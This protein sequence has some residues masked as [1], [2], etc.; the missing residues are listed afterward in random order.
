VKAVPAALDKAGEISAKVYKEEDKSYW[1]KYYKGAQVADKRNLVVDLG[2]STVHNVADNLEI[3]GLNPGST[4]VVKIVYKLFG[5]IVVNLYPKLVPSIPNPDDII[6][7][8]YLRNV[9]SGHQSDVTVVDKPTFNADQSVTQ[10]V[11]EKSWS[12]EFETGSATLTP[13]A[14][15]T[16][17]RLF[18]DLI[19][20]GGLKV[21]VH[22]HTDNVGDPATNMALS[23]KRAFAIKQWLEAKSPSNFPEGRVNVFAH[24]QSNPVAPNDSPTGRAKNRRVAIVLGK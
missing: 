10:K 4:N 14:K 7:V 22:G 11:S 19:V 8:S 21:E 9:A 17:E 18:N 20:A 12:I 23:E 13:A 6:D 16:L 3:F 5:D 2:G 15:Q 24:G 1:V